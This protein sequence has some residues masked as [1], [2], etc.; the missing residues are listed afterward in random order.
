MRFFT[1]KSKW[2]HIREA[3]MAAATDG[4]ELRRLSKVTLGVVAGT[5]AVT[6]ASAAISAV[7]QRQDS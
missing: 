4:V 6:A 2:D 7:R 5:V 3:V 1:R